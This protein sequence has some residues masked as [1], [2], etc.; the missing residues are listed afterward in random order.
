MSAT[1]GHTLGALGALALAVL[2]LSLPSCEA[3]EALWKSGSR[4][5]H[6]R[7]D[8]GN[9]AVAY[10]ETFDSEMKVGCGFARFP[11]GVIRCAPGSSEVRYADATCTKPVVV[12]DGANEDNARFAT[13]F[14]ASVSCGESS[15]SSVGR[16][17]EVDG[18][19]AL[20]AGTQLYAAVGL[21]CQPWSMAD[22]IA[23]PAKLVDPGAFVA[24]DLDTIDGGGGLGI[25]I[26]DGED[27]SRGVLGTR[28]IDRDRPCE[29]EYWITLHEEVEGCIPHPY[30]LASSQTLYTDPAC[31]DGQVARP[32]VCFDEPAE[33]VL[34]IVHRDA[35]GATWALM[36]ADGEVTEGP[37]YAGT[38]DQCGEI[39]SAV[40]PF[41]RVGGPF[42]T[43]SLAQM[44]KMDLGSGRVVA[45]YFGSIHGDPARFY[46][47]FDTELGVGCAPERTSDG[48]TRCLPYH[49]IFG[50]E[51]EPASV[52]YADA[53][54]SEILVELGSN[55]GCDPPV[56][57][58]ASTTDLSLG[59]VTSIRAVVGVET[60]TTV[61]RKTEAGTCVAT[62][63]PTGVAIAR[64]GDAI[65]LATLVEIRDVTE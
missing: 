28:D 58:F 32:A 29:P 61:Y 60:F 15:I 54:C 2:M 26:V 31:S 47:F 51:G 33:A 19:P 6:R 63:A 56:P 24:G 1:R 52:M 37:I 57:R 55:V 9:G 38:P 42:D 39:E 30:G 21:D 34:V 49:S 18:S 44:P 12:T 41:I 53:A 50:F 62:P 3:R 22:A 20:P 17:Y 43:S 65:D 27:G 59:Q 36:Q 45:R 48:A 11:D 64:V 5:K 13:A 7:L 14:D 25:A 23:H 16:I 40:P 35:C 8:A 10:Q 46:S 4:L